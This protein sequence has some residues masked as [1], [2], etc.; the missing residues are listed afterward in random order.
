MP[1][2]KIK[3]VIRNIRRGFTYWSK[4]KNFKDY[5]CAAK[6]DTHK[7]AMKEFEEFCPIDTL[8]EIVE[9]GHKLEATEV[10]Y[11]G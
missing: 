5:D 3:F 1:A 8:V 7:E 10:C 4:E 2:V 9:V 6:F 11:G